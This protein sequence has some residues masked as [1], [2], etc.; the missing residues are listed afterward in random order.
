VTLAPRRQALAVKCA[1]CQRPGRVQRVE[2]DLGPLGVAIW[3]KLPPGW[4][5]FAQADPR[6]LHC[7][8]SA[9]LKV[10]G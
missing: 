4:W 10:K 9:C 1:V 8:C 6:E 3:H 5:L 7:R 2:S